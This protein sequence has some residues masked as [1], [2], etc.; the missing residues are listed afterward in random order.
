MV[1]SH[2]VRRKRLKAPKKQERA[3]QGVVEEVARKVCLKEPHALSTP[4]ARALGTDN[5]CL[6]TCENHLSIYPDEY[7]CA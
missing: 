3:D 5:G 6:K 7:L 2:P 4:W 1:S